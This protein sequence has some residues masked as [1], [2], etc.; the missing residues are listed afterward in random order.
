MEGELKQAFKKFSK[1][2]GRRVGGSLFMG[3]RVNDSL[4]FL[5]GHLWATPK[6]MPPLS[7]VPPPVRP[8]TA[9]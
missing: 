9:P 7:F 6:L 5:C 1:I 2:E 4:V 3:T 8:A